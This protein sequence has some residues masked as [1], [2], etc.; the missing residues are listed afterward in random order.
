MSAEKSVRYGILPSKIAQVF[1]VHERLSFSVDT[2]RA[3]HQFFCVSVRLAY[4]GKSIGAK[5]RVRFTVFRSKSLNFLRHSFS[6]THL[7][8]RKLSKP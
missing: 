3:Q 7:Q 8:A 4:R 1:F 5:G 2:R 6:S